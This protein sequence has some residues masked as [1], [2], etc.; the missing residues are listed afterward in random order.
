M[1]VSVHPQMRRA[2]SAVKATR[3]DA[4]LLRAESLPTV[5][6]TGYQSVQTVN[7]RAAGID[8]STFQGFEGNPIPELFGPFGTFDGRVQ[9]DADVLNLPLQLRQRA[10]RHRVDSEESSTVNARE[11]I[12]MQVVSQYVDALRAQAF[13]ATAVQ[14]LASARALSTITVDRFQ[15]GVASGLDRRRAAA[16]TAAAQQL[17]Y[18]AQAMLEAA[19]LKLAQKLHA[20]I[21]ADYELADI[22]LYFDASPV[23]AADALRTALSARPDYKAAKAAVDSASANAKATRLT[24]LPKLSVHADWGR[25]GRTASTTK[26]TYKLQANV[27]I[28]IYWGGRG[29]AYRTGADAALEAAQANRDAIESQVEMEVRVALSALD[30]ARLQTEAA[31]EAVRLIQEELDLSTVRF[32]Q[33]ITDNSEVV[34]AQERLARAEQAR[35]RALFNVN[36]ARIAMHRAIGNASNTYGGRAR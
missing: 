24:R 13:E 36:M 35:I 16:Q 21:T 17:L 19:K 8:S 31:R 28:P 12:T 11:L 2:E 18:E 3:A 30:S 34:V 20:Q 7:L 15:Q 27:A 5:M 10:A 33:G 14:Q 26:P 29:D 22:D 9:V 25:S 1:A 6:V 23:S 32:Q 4:G